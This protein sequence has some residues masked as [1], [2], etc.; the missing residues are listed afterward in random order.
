MTNRCIV[1]FANGTRAGRI[2]EVRHDPISVLLWERK[3]EPV[4]YRVWF[5]GET[6]P[7]P[8]EHSWYEAN[9]VEVLQ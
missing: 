4:A 9:M 2:I 5:D 6:Q 1:K 7:A 8:D 3:P